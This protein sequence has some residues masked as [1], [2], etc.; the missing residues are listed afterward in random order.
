MEPPT[1]PL[2][3]S[4]LSRIITDRSLVSKGKA[5]KEDALRRLLLL[6]QHAIRRFLLKVARDENC[7]EEVA[8]K[9]LDKLRSGAVCQH[10]VGTR[11]HRFRDYLKQ[12]VRNEFKNFLRARR[13]LC[14]VPLDLT[15][16]P[17]RDQLP[18]AAEDEE[19]LS[20][21]RQSI[22]DHAW[23]AL[24][25]DAQ[26]ILRIW[27]ELNGELG[28]QPAEGHRR[29]YKRLAARLAEQTGRVFT[30]AALRQQVHRARERFA[31]FLRGAVAE[32]LK[33]PTPGAVTAELCALGLYEVVRDFSSESMKG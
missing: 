13:G 33:D 29:S 18:G 19:L 15:L 17:S 2:P 7:A 14:Q 10:W 27:A 16:V 25:E 11:G 4:H 20:E 1:S 9:F 12:S 26:T 31:G 22:L 30:P 6:Y 3:E 24:K 23:K 21:L 32:M 8:D 28:E 5:G